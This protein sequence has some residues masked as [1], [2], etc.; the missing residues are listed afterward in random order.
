MKFHWFKIL[1]LIARDQSGAFS[2][3]LMN[4]QSPDTLGRAKKFRTFD[5]TCE[6]FS[7]E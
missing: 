1:K 5:Q 7:H 6:I 2:L 3:S 4:F